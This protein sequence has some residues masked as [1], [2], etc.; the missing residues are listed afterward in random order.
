MMDNLELFTET[1]FTDFQMAT[2]EQIATGS[3]RTSPN[4]ADMR[5]AAFLS[6]IYAAFAAKLHLFIL[7]LVFIAR[8][9]HGRQDEQF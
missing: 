6:L 5:Q 8:L 7:H 4:E 9:N 1:T 3:G 2:A